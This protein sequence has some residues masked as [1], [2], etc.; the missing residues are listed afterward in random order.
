M[1]C[2]GYDWFQVIAA[3]RRE[4]EEEEDVLSHPASVG[5]SQSSSLRPRSD[6]GLVRWRVEEDNWLLVVLALRHS[7]KLYGD[8]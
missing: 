8:D 4:E 3:D 7:W 2:P 5:R 6:S 1:W